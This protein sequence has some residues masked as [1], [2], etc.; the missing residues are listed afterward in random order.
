[1]T[2]ISPDQDFTNLWELLISSNAF[3]IAGQICSVLSLII[4]AADVRRVHS[5]IHTTKP[6]GV[7]WT[8]RE[9]N[10][11]ISGKY[12]DLAKIEDYPRSRLPE[13]TREN[14]HGE[15]RDV[16]HLI[17]LQTQLLEAYYIFDTVGA[18]VSSHR[19]W[20]AV[21]VA[22]LIAAAGICL[23]VTAIFIG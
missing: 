2:I 23:Q 19:S 16:L 9:I 11:R 4:M 1:M 17:Q 5:D 3:N 14:L 13:V 21:W 15:V 20:N 10:L 18:K 7:D 8:E 22:T 12:K 6:K